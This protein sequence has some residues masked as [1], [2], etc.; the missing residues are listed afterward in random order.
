MISF[1]NL[2]TGLSGNFPFYPSDE[3][4]TIERP[5]TVKEFP[6][7]GSRPVVQI[8]APGMKKLSMRLIF[9]GEEG[10]NFYNNVIYRGYGFSNPRSIP[11]EY[12][13]SWGAT[14]FDTFTGFSVGMPPTDFML[15]V[16]GD[17]FGVWSM[18]FTF[19]LSEI[20]NP[21]T[22]ELNSKGQIIASEPPSLNYTVKPGDTLQSICKQFKCTFAE[23]ADLNPGKNILRPVPGQ[24]LKIPKRVNK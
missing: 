13:I 17:V 10:R 15:G 23:L 12:I 20:Q 16:E 11:H 9:Y 19:E 21:Q 7:Q 4:I 3:K 24:T 6:V 1:I 14:Q 18:D 2:T 22:R 8:L 5:Q